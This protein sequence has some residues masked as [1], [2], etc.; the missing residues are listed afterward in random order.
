ML[1]NLGLATYGTVARVVVQEILFNDPTLL[2]SYQT[3]FVGHVYPGETLNIR[4]WKEGNLLIYEAEVE[5]RKK[6]ALIGYM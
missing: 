4:V 1:T 2:K 3:R 6:K 5:E